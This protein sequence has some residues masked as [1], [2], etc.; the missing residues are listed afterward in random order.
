MW[1]S[2]RGASLLLI[3]VIV[4]LLAIFAFVIF[5]TATKPKPAEIKAIPKPTGVVI[6]N[7]PAATPSRMPAV[8]AAPQSTPAS[9]GH[10]LKRAPE[11][12][13][14]TVTFS[15]ASA[16]SVLPPGQSPP[17]GTSSFDKKI[18]V[19][20][21]KD[22][23]IEQDTKAG[24]IPFVICHMKGLFLSKMPNYDKWIISA[25]CPLNSFTT[26]DYSRA[27][28]AGFDWISDKNYSG[29]VLVAN[30]K[31]FV[32]R[33]KTVVLEPSDL[34]VMN[35]AAQNAYAAYA[36]RKSAR[37]YGHLASGDNPNEQAP[38]PFNPN[39][40]KMDV[41]AVIDAEAGLP[42]QLVYGTL[43]GVVTRT[44]QFQHAAERVTLPA[45]AQA[46]LDAHL[47]RMKRFSQGPRRFPQ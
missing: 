46:A 25:K 40:Y 32:F 11:Q 18:V 24:G 10:C 35:I 9:P 4:A 15:T 8:K 31:C 39:D 13:Q 33:D 6:A 28:F 2:Q 21:G 26:T 20:K 47:E 22:L 19:T 1:R 27:D 3:L 5:S 45:D 12:T 34:Q 23:L 43:G 41:T 14:W 17:T 30:R 42:V 44:Y 38:P 37:E 16:K 7:K 29:E 36:I